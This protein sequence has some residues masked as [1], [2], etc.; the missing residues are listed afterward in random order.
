MTTV[1]AAG[2]MLE[3]IDGATEA[4]K[5][6]MHYPCQDKGWLERFESVELLV[7]ELLGGGPAGRRQHRIQVQVGHGGIVLDAVSLA[8]RDAPTL[9]IAG[10]AGR[11]ES[12]LDIGQ[13]QLSR[14]ELCLQTA[15]E[16]GD[17]AVVVSPFAGRHGQR[18]SHEH[19]STA[20][21]RD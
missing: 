2:S 16:H 6:N 8:L 14:Q 7:E 18:P 20:L 5:N 3:T 12:R 15:A 11:V 4:G 13:A 21:A 10:A 9:V 19:C 17:G 1:N